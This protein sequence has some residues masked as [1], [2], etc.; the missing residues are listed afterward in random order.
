MR[1]RGQ[2][3]HRF[4]GERTEGRCNAGRITTNR[5]TLTGLLEPCAV[6]AA[7]TVLGGRG[8]A[9]CPGYPTAASCLALECGPSPRGPHRA[10][11]SPGTAARL[12]AARAG[13][14][15]CPS[16]PKPTS[17][18]PFRWRAAHDERRQPAGM[19]RR[20]PA[21]GRTCA[22]SRAPRRGPGGGASP[23]LPALRTEGSGHAATVYTEHGPPAVPSG[24]QMGPPRPLAVEQSVRVGGLIALADRAAEIP[25]VHVPLD[26]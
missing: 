2:V 11:T 4:G 7:S 15:D 25:S 10:G 20:T 16:A 5:P 22:S 14:R 17:G 1:T 23:V 9:M 19:Q 24:L 18:T 12:G 13:G 6:R 26:G 3:G 8:T 21:S